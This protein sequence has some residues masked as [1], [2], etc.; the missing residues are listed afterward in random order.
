MVLSIFSCV[1]WPCVCLLWRNAC[2]GLPPIFWLGCLF[3][4]ILSYMSYLY[5]LEI[6]PLSVASLAN[7]FCHCECCLF[8]YGF[9]CCAKKLL[10]LIRSHLL[11]FI[12]IF[13]EVYTIDIPKSVIFLFTNKLSEKLRKKNLQLYQ[14]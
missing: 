10:T 14:K 6:N 4:F 1:C 5:I 2:V 12:F 3:F 8:V 9:L 13:I 11:I 7:I